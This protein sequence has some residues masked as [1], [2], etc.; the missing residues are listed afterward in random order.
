MI[1]NSP[2]IS[3]SLTVTGNIIT[4]G[5]ITISGSIASA[6][7]ASNADLLDGLDSTVFTLTSSFNAQ[8]ASFTAFSSS[9]NSFSA[10]ILSYTASQNITNGTFTTTASFNA[11]TASFTAFTSSINAFSASVLT[12]TGSAATRLNALEA[13]TSSLYS[14]T[15]SLNNKTSSFATTGSNAFIGTQTITGSVLQSGSFTSTGTLTAQTLV[16]QTITSSVVYSS[17]SNIFGNAIGNTQTFTGSVLVTGSL[18]IA[19]GSSATSYSGATIYGSTVACSPVGKFT[20]CIDAGSGIFSS[21]VTAGGKFEASFSNTNTTFDN[22]AYLRLVNTGTSTLNQRVDLIMRW[23]DGT[24][25]GTGGISMVR[26]SATA[27]S[28][29]LVLQP[30]ASDGN[31]VEALTLASTG[32]ATF[33]STITGTTI[34]GSTVV[35]S[36]VGYFSG[37]VGIGTSSPSAKLEISGFSTGA[38]LKLNYGN[39]SGIIEA[40]NFIANGGS[41]GVIGMQMVSAG[42]GDLWLGGSGGRSLTLYRD[43]NV[44]IGTSSPSDNLHIVACEA[45]NVGVTVQNTNSSYSSQL[46]FLNSTGTEKAAV[47]FVQSTTSLNLNVNQIDALIIS[48]TGTTTFACSINAGGATFLD[49][50]D[51]CL[52]LRTSNSGNPRF[53]FCGGGGV[54]NRSTAADIMYFGESADTGLYLFRGGTLMSDKGAC[55]GTYGFTHCGSG[56]WGRIGL[57][58]TSYMYLETNANAG[59]YVD[60]ALQIGGNVCSSGQV[61]GTNLNAAGPICGSGFRSG[62]SSGNSGGYTSD[63]LWGATATPNYIDTT[64]AMGL[65]LGYTDNGSGLYGAAYGFDVSYKDGLNNCIDYNAIMMRNSGQGTIPFRVTSYGNIYGNSK[66]FRIKHPIPSMNDTHYLIHTSIEGPQA[67]LIYRGKTQLVNGKAEVN[68]DLASR[69]TNGTFEALCQDIQSYTTNESGWSLTK[70][71]VVEN[72]LH[73]EA[74]DETSDDT[75]SWLVIGERND[76]GIKNSAITDENGHVIVEELKPEEGL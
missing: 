67:D 21:S 46:R 52:V 73:I 5:S 37:C 54:F 30:I 15:S 6:S 11:Q 36:A 70:S 66:N 60:A 22:S 41:N 9:I 2:T 7:Y 1:L 76:D 31:N 38:G 10:S 58:N 20:S 63:G 64:S 43:G 17:G 50:G 28:G 13:A 40:V 62:A 74:Q 72:I 26:E 8:T 14:Y 29:K 75:I 42:V 18:T 3:G 19:G 48:S 65:K 32:A 25:N 33:S 53:K 59:V 12:F 35:C 61:K 34:Y 16:V 47:T 71:Y 23:Q 68:I 69:M 49:T 57:P 4:S 45:G 55:T 56:K 27:R 44:G 24:Y 39:S 51:T